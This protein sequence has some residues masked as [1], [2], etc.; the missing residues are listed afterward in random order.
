MISKTLPSIGQGYSIHRMQR[1][2]Y[3]GLRHLCIT[4]ITCMH[5]PTLHVAI[6][7]KK[8]FSCI[9]TTTPMD[10]Q[11]NNPFTHNSELFP[12]DQALQKCHFR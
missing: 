5:Q 2:L 10:F 6:K 1:Y 11:N 9:D 4:S 7:V 8:L 3:I 12:H